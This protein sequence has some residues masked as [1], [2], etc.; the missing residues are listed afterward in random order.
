MNFWRTISSLAGARTAK[1]SCD[2]CPDGLPGEDP[3][4]SAAVTALG[5]KLA[6]A[7]GSAD[8][9]EF[10][11]FMALVPSDLLVLLDEASS[12]ANS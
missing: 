11:A 10:E 8:A 1:A 2:D 5:A 7:D 12:V 4:F 9:A 3:R 6:M